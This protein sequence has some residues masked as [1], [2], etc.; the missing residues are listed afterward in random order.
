MAGPDF[1]GYKEKLPDKQEVGSIGERSDLSEDLGATLLTNVPD[2]DMDQALAVQALVS[3]FR[4]YIKLDKGLLVRKVE[5]TE[6]PPKDWQEIV[7]VVSEIKTAKLMQY[8]EGNLENVP[9]DI[10]PI[11]EGFIAMREGNIIGA[12]KSFREYIAESPEG[13]G[14]DLAK[15]LLKEIALIRLA[16]ARALLSLNL[17]DLIDSSAGYLGQS[18]IAGLTKNEGI[19]SIDAQCK[20]LNLVEAV[21]KGENSFVSFE[22]AVDYVKKAASINEKDY[23]NKTLGGSINLSP[24]EA[25]FMEAKI[26]T[27]QH[28]LLN[29]L[30]GNKFTIDS[31]TQGS[32]LYVIDEAVAMS[33]NVKLAPEALLSKAKQFRKDKS[34]ERATNMFDQL[35]AD[36][37]QEISDRVGGKERFIEMHQSEIKTLASKGGNEEQIANAMWQKFLRKSVAKDYTFDNQNP[38]LQEAQKEFDDM[39]ELKGED[40]GFLDLEAWGKSDKDWDKFFE[41]MPAEVAVLAAS[42]GTA[43]LAGAATKRGLLAAM[44]KGGTEGAEEFVEATLKQEILARSGGFAVESLA[45]SETKGFLSALRHGTLNELCKKDLKT[46][47]KEWGHSAVTLGTLKSVMKAVGKLPEGAKLTDKMMHNAAVLGGDVVAMTTTEYYWQSLVEGKKL[48][49]KE[50]TNLVVDNTLLSGVMRGVDKAKEGV[51]GKD[52]L[53]EAARAEIDALAGKLKLAPEA[54][55]AELA[56]LRELPAFEKLNKLMEQFIDG[57]I[58]VEAFQK[59]AAVSLSAI[60]SACGDSVEGRALKGLFDL[61]TG[62]LGALGIGGLISL[63]YVSAPVVKESRIRGR[64]NNGLSR[65]EAMGNNLKWS[66]ILGMLL[67]RIEKPTEANRAMNEGLKTKVEEVI[68]QLNLIANSIP[69]NTPKGQKTKQKLL[70]AIGRVENRMDA[71]KGDLLHL[72]DG[73]STNLARLHD[74]PL[75]NELAKDL[76]HLTKVVNKLASERYFGPQGKEAL[77]STG[78]RLSAITAIVLIG[79]AVNNYKKSEDNTE[80]DSTDPLLERKEV[81][82]N[83][84][85][86]SLEGGLPNL[87]ESPSTTNKRGVAKRKKTN[88]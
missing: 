2:Y 60:L 37:Y 52:P 3:E 25:Y 68:G 34:Y 73:G 49:G 88:Q 21:I 10:R 19:R 20:F 51:L 23:K 6:I 47:L 82:N 5:L 71:T 83:E 59:A 30:E 66:G 87:D 61:S 55:I 33:K 45:F 74:A 15:N 72:L 46:H 16:D 18:G 43:A 58:S 8:I 63:V 69:V 56:R 32:T 31:K 48:S 12:E 40:Y 14:L 78:K 41:E 57:K 39:L 36:T 67:N 17:K 79:L 28:D 77:I 64:M 13:I 50:L 85:D 27:S 1:I 76:A 35:F 53:S 81:L 9:E 80:E 4:S 44:K 84:S 65:Q 38:H 70:E 22:D 11:L 7:S 54:L 42:G 75:R 24:I 86:S 26:A 29:L 62:V